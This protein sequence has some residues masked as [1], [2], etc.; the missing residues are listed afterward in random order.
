MNDLTS[1]QVVMLTYL[2]V[3]LVAL[4]I[5]HLI[6]EGLP[7][8]VRFHFQQMLTDEVKTLQLPSYSQEPEYVITNQ[9]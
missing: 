2:T 9:C 8:H 3:V 1:M 4:S 5:N 7:E 6:S